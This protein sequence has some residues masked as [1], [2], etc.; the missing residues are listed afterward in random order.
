MSILYG[1]WRY[2]LINQQINRKRCMTGL[3]VLGP[4]IATF[5]L[6]AAMIAILIVLFVI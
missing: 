2:Y 4:V 3:Q 6:T 5:V 1:V